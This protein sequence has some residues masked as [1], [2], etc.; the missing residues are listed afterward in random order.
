MQLKKIKVDKFKSGYNKSLTFTISSRIIFCLIII[1]SIIC[2]TL[3]LLVN[4]LIESTQQQ[5][6]DN[7]ADINSNTVSSY[8]NNINTI[9]L[10]LSDFVQNIQKN[11]VSDKEVLLTSKLNTIVDK[12]NIFSA[13]LAFEPNSIKENT[14]NGLSYYV[15]ENNSSKSIDIL[16][17]YKT[18][19]VGDYYLPTKESKSTHI[20]E[21]YKYTLSN[22]NVVWIISICNP[23]FDGNGK[24]I[25]VATCDILTESINKLKY[26]NGGFK[27]S[28][29]YTLTEK[30]T[31]VSHGKSSD[32]IGKSYNKNKSSDNI[33]TVTSPLKIS[34]CKQSW[35]NGLVVNKSELTLPAL[36]LTF[37]ILAI[38]I[39]GIIILSIICYKVIKTS[40]NPLSRVVNLAKRMGNGDLKVNN[41]D[42]LEINPENVKNEVLSLAVI[43]NQTSSKLSDYISDISSV[44]NKISI[45]DL[46]V[47][48]DK[49]YVG[50]FVDIKNSLENI[51][52]SLNSTLGEIKSSSEQVYSASDL[53]AS[54]SQSLS[55][56]ATEQASAICEISSTI[57]SISELIKENAKRTSEINKLSKN[58]STEVIYSN[59]K[60]KQMIETMNLID[61]KSRDIVKI[62]KTI[63]DI[64][65]ETNILALNAAVEAARA[66]NAGKGFSVVANEVRNLANKSTEAAKTTTEL[67]QSSIDVIKSGSKLMDETGN[68]MIKVTESVDT[69][70]N[71]ISGIND[72]LQNESESINNI[73]IGFNEI[74]TVTQNNSALSEEVAATSEELNA[75]AHSLLELV[76]KFKLTN[77]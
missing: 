68:S 29:S 2:T 61:S 38:A 75:C 35:S 20:T 56:G 51:I 11:N 60:M 18:Y 55:Q 58:A 41:R 53:S 40:L 63:E 33:F 67:I 64:A 52:N 13:Y 24:F 74:S 45:G 44:L 7:I 71:N 73:N 16:E 47:N 22:G 4:N 34:D 77:M 54:S 31:Y 62:I 19:S 32:L 15:Y 48:I 72:A 57:N 6:L 9:S 17:D 10:E 25:G 23:I 39:I 65:Y 26:N 69:I 43:L 70:V 66:G 27:S 49:E 8:L 59:E 14:P 36:K 37:T 5:K 50:E 30:G 3:Y 21:P 28:Y 1:I 46:C 76:S 42:F 12:D